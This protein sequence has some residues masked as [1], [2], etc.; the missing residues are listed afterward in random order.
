MDVSISGKQWFFSSWLLVYPTMY[1]LFCVGTAGFLAEGSWSWKGLQ[2]ALLCDF[3]AICDPSEIEWC[4]SCQVKRWLFACHFAHLRFISRTR[5]ANFSSWDLTRSSTTE[6]SRRQ[7]TSIGPPN[8]MDKDQECDKL[9]GQSINRSLCYLKSTSHGHY[10]VMAWSRI[11]GNNHWPRYQTNFQSQAA[12]EKSSR[13][14]INSL[15]GGRSLVTTESQNQV[16]SGRQFVS[17]DSRGSPS[18]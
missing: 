11:K 8:T 10:T 13:E 18:Q 5:H 6:T 16:S 3:L 14:R 9:I 2:R 12:A 17:P 1:L 7:T 4:V 15:G